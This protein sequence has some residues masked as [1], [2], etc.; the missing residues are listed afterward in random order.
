MLNFSIVL[1]K[2]S[3]LVEGS[4]VATHSFLGLLVEFEKLENNGNID[5]GAFL[6]LITGVISLLFEET[7]KFDSKDENQSGLG[8][9]LWL[10]LEKVI[11]RCEVISDYESK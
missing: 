4:Q 11:A 2:I 10:E 6:G 7:I 8:P 5:D 1:P 9:F 3:C